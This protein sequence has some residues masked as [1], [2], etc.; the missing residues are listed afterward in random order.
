M[1]FGHEEPRGC[2]DWEHGLTRGGPTL[3][4]DFMMLYFSSDM[5]ATLTGIK[6]WDLTQSA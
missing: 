1:T 4:A 5:V 3:L 6:G 2:L